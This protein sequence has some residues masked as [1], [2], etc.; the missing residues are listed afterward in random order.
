M[1]DILFELLAKFE[2]RPRDLEYRPARICAQ[3]IMWSMKTSLEM[4][5]IATVKIAREENCRDL[6]VESIPGSTTVGVFIPFLPRFKHIFSDQFFPTSTGAIDHLDTVLDRHSSW[7]GV[8]CSYCGTT[9]FVITDNH[10]WFSAGS[11]PSVVPELLPAFMLKGGEV[12]HF[13][14][15]GADLMFPGISIPAERVPP[16]QAGQPWA[17]IV[18]NNVA[19][20]AVGTTTMSSIESRESVEGHYIPNARFL[21]D[22]ALK[23][24]T[25]ALGGLISDSCGGTCNTS[26]QHNGTNGEVADIGDVHSEHHLDKP[27]IEDYITEEIIS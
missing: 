18:P 24:P 23:D 8:L 9:G 19:P 7:C 5:K 12:S 16:F 10:Q 6:Q 21:E 11:L 20:I 13:I 14:I 26:S 2:K 4:M 15:G 22:V 1:Y 3:L 27:H 17:V 25:L